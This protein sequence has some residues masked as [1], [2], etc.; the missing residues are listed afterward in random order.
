MNTPRI[1]NV[2]PLENKRLRVTFRDNTIKIYDFN[3]L[4]A[5]ER[6]RLLREEAFFRAVRVDS[7]GYGIS[8][9]DDLDLSEN[10][11]W[12]NG[13]TVDTPQVAETR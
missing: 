4:L 3:P 12:Q 2:I 6:F 8:W 7:G 11:L 13:V 1:Q 5:T 9:N 10:E